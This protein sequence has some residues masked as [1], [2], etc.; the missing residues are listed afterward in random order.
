MHAIAHQFTVINSI[1]VKNHIQIN[2]L[3]YDTTRNR[4]FQR[5]RGVAG[6]SSSHLPSM[7]KT[8]LSSPTS[9]HTPY[10]TL[11]TSTCVQPWPLHIRQ[12]AWH[13]NRDVTKQ[14]LPACARSETVI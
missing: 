8:N 3:V 5:G 7:L 6:V 9:Y 1:N 4:Y 12:V 11:T 10:D 13:L 14:K 2:T